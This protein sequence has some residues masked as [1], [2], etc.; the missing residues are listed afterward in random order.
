MILDTRSFDVKLSDRTSKVSQLVPR[1]E[2]LSALEGVEGGW[3][4][5]YPVPFH[6]DL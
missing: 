2:S 1:Q 6:Q 5:G 3:G 4:K